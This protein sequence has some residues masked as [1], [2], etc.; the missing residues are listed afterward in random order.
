[1]TT[2]SAPAFPR[3]QH[4]TTGA[5]RV[6]AMAYKTEPHRCSGCGTFPAGNV[7]WA[8]GRGDREGW[9]GDSAWFCDS[10][11]PPRG[12]LPPL[13]YIRL[14]QGAGVLPD[15]V[16]PGHGPVIY[17]RL[18]PWPGQACGE[19]GA[20]PVYRAEY[21]CRGCG[22]AVMSYTVT[23]IG[24]TAAGDPQD[25]PV[26]RAHLIHTAGWAFRCAEHPFERHPELT[27]R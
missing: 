1:L 20:P 4:W 13:D 14:I 21:L 19:C 23:R 15:R 25:G 18:E 27:A 16:T 3:S 6:T 11:R 8:D 9:S 24:V 26:A 17:E 7:L 5:F 10:C 22:D 12:P 2:A